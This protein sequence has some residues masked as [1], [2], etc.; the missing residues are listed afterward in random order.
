MDHNENKEIAKDYHD[1]KIEESMTRK[2]TGFTD[3]SKYVRMI[4]NRPSVSLIPPPNRRILAQWVGTNVFGFSILAAI[5][6]GI[7]LMEYRN[8]LSFRFYDTRKR[9]H[10][11]SDPYSGNVSCSY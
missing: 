8:Q 9:F 1:I 4:K 6:G 3:E 2:L 10:F 5:L 7:V 11:K